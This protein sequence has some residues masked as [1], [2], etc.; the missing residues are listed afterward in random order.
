M[1]RQDKR[2]KKRGR[3]TARQREGEREWLHMGNFGDISF[4]FSLNWCV[5]LQGPIIKLFS[6]YPN[7][8]YLNLHIIS[9]FLLFPTTYQMSPFHF[10]Y[11]PICN[12]SLSPSLCLAVSLPLFFSLLS[13][14]FLASLYLITISYIFSLPNCYLFFIFRIIHMYLQ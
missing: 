13:C 9:P 14:L 12:H 11:F 2:E 1:K 3:E 4:S 8:Y 6:F 10:H 5:S 7:C